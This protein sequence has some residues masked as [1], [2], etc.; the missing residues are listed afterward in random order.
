MPLALVVLE[1]P[2][3]SCTIAPE[4]GTSES[5]AV[6]VPVNVPCAGARQEANLNLPILV[7]Q[8]NELFV[9]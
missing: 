6:T 4:M 8:L 5:Q 9:L 1:N 2:L 7:R 3:E